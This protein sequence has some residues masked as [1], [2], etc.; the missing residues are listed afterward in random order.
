MASA[1]SLNS[2]KERQPSLLTSKP[3]KRRRKS[4]V[5]PPP[6]FAA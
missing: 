6:S 2:S 1:R 3:L 5:P 4:W